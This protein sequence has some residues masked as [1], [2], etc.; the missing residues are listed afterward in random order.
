MFAGP[1]DRHSGKRTGA[2]PSHKL[3]GGCKQVNYSAK[4]RRDEHLKR[5]QDVQYHRIPK[6]NLGEHKQAS[7]RT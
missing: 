2:V 5:G 3:R 4:D 7:E 1:I 6:L